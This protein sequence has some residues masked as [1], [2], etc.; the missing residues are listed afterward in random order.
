MASKGLVILIFV[1]MASSVSSAVI[2]TFD[3]LGLGAESYWKLTDIPAT[4]PIFGVSCASLT[5][6]Y[7][8]SGTKA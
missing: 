3:D 8:G 5:C 6:W 1:L 2:A 4:T 7:T